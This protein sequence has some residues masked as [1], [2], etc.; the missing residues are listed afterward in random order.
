MFASNFPT[1]KLF[2]S[3]DAIWQAF[4][5][6]TADFSQD[7]RDKLFA[8]NANQTLSAANLEKGSEPFSGVRLEI[9][10]KGSDPFS[11][12]HRDRPRYHRSSRSR[13]SGVMPV[14]LPSGMVGVATVT[15]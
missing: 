13:S 14:M 2:S 15:W 7:E 3:M 10:E 6:I 5:S 12:P 8:G 9:G 11:F 1:D 4:L